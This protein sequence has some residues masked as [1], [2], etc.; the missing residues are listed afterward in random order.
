MALAATV[1]RGLREQMC[2]GLLMQQLR[3]LAGSAAAAQSA[4][5]AAAEA[6]APSENAAAAGPSVKMNLCTA[7]N[8]ALHIAME[9][10]SK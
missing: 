2:C 5:V 7:V 10:N 8:D 1:R 9:E 6:A 3:G 4:A